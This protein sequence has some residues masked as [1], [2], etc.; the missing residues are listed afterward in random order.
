MYAVVVVAVFVSRE[1]SVRSTKTIHP[2]FTHIH[3]NADDKKRKMKKQQ[4]AEDDD[5][6]AGK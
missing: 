4:Q 1:D 6:A 5:C 3:Q 2:Q